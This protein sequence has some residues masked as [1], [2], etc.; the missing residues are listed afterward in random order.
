MTSCTARRPDE[1]DTRTS[2]RLTYRTGT[3]HRRAHRFRPSQR[4]PHARALKEQSAA[5][6]RR[7]LGIGT[8]R[9]LSENLGRRDWLRTGELSPQELWRKVP[10]AQIV[11]LAG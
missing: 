6:R 3:A 4:A 10:L 1:G 9:R 8:T 7:A 2:V 11:A 5:E